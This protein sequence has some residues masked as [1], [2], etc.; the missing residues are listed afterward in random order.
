MSGERIVERERER[1]I[2]S[3]VREREMLTVDMRSSS[4]RRPHTP[5]RLV[6]EE[7]EVR[8]ISPRPHRSQS[9][10]PRRRRR[11]TPGRGVERREPSP[12]FG[13]EVVLVQPNRYRDRDIQDEIRALENEK[14]ALQLER[15]EVDLVVDDH[16]RDEVVEVKKDRKGRMSLVR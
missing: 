2:A 9:V 10:R 1:I 15:R 3:P 5:E 16:E 13:Q 14:R 11:S 7:R 12:G 8:E 6:R 4:R